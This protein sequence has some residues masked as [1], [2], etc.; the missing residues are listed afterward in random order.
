MQNLPL[1]GDNAAA[2]V[3]AVPEVCYNG[4]VFITQDN[5]DNFMSDNMP[6]LDYEFYQ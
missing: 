4:T 5:V 2:G 3:N 1:S 6:Q